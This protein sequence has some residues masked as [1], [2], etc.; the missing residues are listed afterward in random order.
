MMFLPAPRASW[1]ATILFLV[2]FLGLSACNSRSSNAGD[3]GG[4]CFADHTCNHGNKCLDRTCTP[5]ALGTLGCA[6]ADKTTCGEGLACQSGTCWEDNGPVPANPV[7]YT[8]CRQGIT[9]STGTYLECSADGLMK[10]CLDGAECTHG[11]CVR[12]ASA[13]QTPPSDAGAGLGAD[14]A[15]T[16][17][18]ATMSSSNGVSCGG[19]VECPDFQV[20]IQG[21]CYS[22]CEYDSD[23][24]GGKKCY[25]K[26]CRMPCS[27]SS[28]SMQTCP[29]STYCAALDSDNGFCMP[30]KNPPVDGGTKSTVEG[31]YDLSSDAFHF[32]NTNITQTFTLTNHAPR[33]LEFTITKME[34]TEYADTG[35]NH[36]TTN[37]LPWVT[38]GEKGKAAKVNAFKFT[39]DGN[40]GSLDLEVNSNDPMAP[41]KWDG[42]LQVTSGEL[43]NRRITMDYAAAADGRW[44]G[45]AYYFAQFGDRNLDTWMATRDD[46]MALANV[47]NAFVQEWG[48]I[49]GGRISVDEFNAV[50]T[51]TTTD[52]WEW[53][54][55]KNVCPTAA[56]YLYTNADGFGRYSDSLSDQPVPTGVS[57]L[58]VAL[59]LK[60]VDSLNLTGRIVSSESL[61]YAGDPAIS[62]QFAA[63]PGQCSTANSSAC[64]ALV[65]SLDATIVVGGRYLADA[66]DTG[67]S[68]AS[69][70]QLI[71]TPWLPA[72]MDPA[73]IPGFLGRSSDGGSGASYVYECRDTLQPSGSASVATNLSLAGSN[74]IPDGSSRTRQIELVDGMLVN[75]DTLFL[76]FREHFAEHFLGSGDKGFA[77]YGLIVL[78]RT[79]AQLDAASFQ[80]TNQG[81]TRIPSAN[82][83]GTG[84]A[85]DALPDALK[86]RLQNGMSDDDIA[87][88]MLDGVLPGNATPLNSGPTKVLIHY[89]CHDTGLFDKGPDPNNPA[90]CPPGSGVTF[91][92]FP[93]P[94]GPLGP[95]NDLSGLDCQ[96]TK[97]CQATLDDWKNA[98][99]PA[100]ASP[101]APPSPPVSSLNLNPTWRCAPLGTP[102]C[103]DD[104]TDLTN[105]KLFF[106][107]SNS[108]QVFTPLPAAIDDAFRYKTKFQSRQGTNLGFT[109]SRCVPNSNSVPYCY[110]AR[111][112]EEIRE[113][114]D[115]LA[116]LFKK[117][118]LS[119]GTQT[120]VR[121]YLTTNFADSQVAAK[122]HDGFELLNAEL[123]IMLGD[124][125]Y[126]AAFQS[127]FDLADSA[128][129]AFE[130]SKFEHN[131]IDLAGGAGFEMYTLYL[132]AQ[133]YQ[134][135]LDRF[136]SQF[137]FIAYATDPQNA[138][139]AG[140]IIS[141]T[142]VVDY[143]KRVQRAST[144]KSRAWSEIG[145]RYE[146]L[147]RADL[148][149]AV[150]SR[151]YTSTYLEAILVSR[152]MQRIY[153][154]TDASK[155]DQI[156]DEVNRAALSYRAALLDMRGVYA[157][158]TDN[159]NY[160]GFAPDYIPFPPL[161][162]NGPNAFDVAFTAATQALTTARD[163]EDLA[164]SQNRAFETDS[165]SFQSQ[166]A[167]IKNTY[168]NQ[169]AD[170]CGTFKGNDGQVYPAT[171]AYAYLS[172]ATKRLGDPCGLVG[173]GSITDAFG[174]VNVAGVDIQAVRNSFDT[175]SR[176][177]EIERQKANTLCQIDTSLADYKFKIQGRVDDLQAAIRAT[178]LSIDATQRNL[179]TVEQVAQLASC[180]LGTS[181]SCSQAFVQV[182]VVLGANQFANADIASAQQSIADKQDTIA[183]LQRSE[184]V[185]EGKAQC[186]SQQVESNA[187]IA[188]YY[189]K[190]NEL[191]LDALKA[192][193]NL[194]LKLA[195]VA[196]LHNQATRLLAEQQESQQLAINVEAAKNDPNVRIYKNDAILNADRTFYD[197][198]QAVYKATRVFEYYTSQSYAKLDDLLLVRLVTRGDRPLEAYLSD[199][200]GAYM[201]FRENFGHPD[202]RVEIE[203][204]RDDILNIPRVGE[205]GAALTQT[206]RVRRFR[207]ALANPAL[208]DAHGYLTV[209]FSTALTRLSPLTRDHKI[210]YIE[211]EIIGSDVG[212]NVGRVYLRQ[213]GTGMVDSVDGAKT[214]YRFPAL[215][216]VVNTLFNGVRTFTPDV[217]R[218]DRL[219]D[220]PFVN[221]HWDFVLN[222][223]DEAANQDIN[224]ESLTDVRLYVY[225]SDLTAL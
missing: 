67:C 118:Q 52:A 131:G 51:A 165:A 160:F 87:T 210:L 86:G 111:A 143:F 124:D 212:D 162:T 45:K 138:P 29:A 203:S 150:V 146:S 140:G 153:D 186:D 39:V 49:R 113:R 141:Q 69:G 177:I 221:T 215:T 99:P 157:D 132:A 199:L 223:R 64:I 109:P 73:G 31:S 104:R 147:N 209:P 164:I 159:V 116:Y 184:I 193:Y 83:L 30:L 107:T 68:K 65:Q 79:R 168:D 202:T 106:P 214:Y 70:F 135:I 54:S 195:D 198:L 12:P 36:I 93:V 142:T 44:A 37:P 144:Q 158:L 2:G 176:E 171:S 77:A 129:A 42:V 219:R 117:G 122:P 220:R 204:L 88:A 63:D 9:D 3:V 120:I 59:D 192:D 105:G 139:V 136:Y 90:T 149:R 6:C 121:T 57:E 110:D 225:Y 23:C 95:P 81:E 169:L 101:P 92:Y 13:R 173:N 211:A 56:C 151:A 74:P 15:V 27:T 196:K 166:L 55:V 71:K 60:V 28:T 172:Q 123:L 189:L 91:F 181:E 194:Q 133:Y 174:A 126:T 112:I 4:A 213:S 72:A 201:T 5:C 119:Q 161:D 167:Q 32:S 224:L 103:D 115:C 58:P 8:P 134:M 197:A 76:M 41:K 130:G 175:I 35:P 1:L 24:T 190:L 155:R 26:S 62:L 205:D 94:A 187:M 34:H 17:R 82:A 10:A 11:S 108:A 178:Q 20:C 128:R 33:A 170:I 14:A 183:Q 191:S 61:H 48:K 19:N 207:A 80:G 114:V 21:T 102:Y 25:R 127:R 16:A 179:K 156:R 84:N 163:K 7:C 152:I 50:I 137:P 217:Y 188:G 66:T 216:A 96:K 22:N 145:K 218:G 180:S 89:L 40:D 100:F 222:Q 97:T 43:G 206:E 85:C 47:G 182:A 125:A 98:T 148:A 200:Q 185:V 38:M 154:V 18:S 53:P 75:Q 78:R 208:L 46:E